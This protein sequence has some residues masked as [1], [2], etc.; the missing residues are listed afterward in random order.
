MNPEQK[1]NTVMK[2]RKRG[3]EQKQACAYND[4]ALRVG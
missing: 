1:E 3:N 2:R 4:N